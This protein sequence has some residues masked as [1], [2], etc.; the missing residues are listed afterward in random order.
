MILKTAFLHRPKSSTT[1]SI[2]THLKKNIREDYSVCF[3]EDGTL[4]P[5]DADT[6]SFMLSTLIKTG[7]ITRDETLAIA[8]RIADNQDEGKIQIYFRPE[9]HDRKNR[10]DHVALCNICYFLYSQ[11][12]KEEAGNQLSEIVAFFQKKSHLQ[13]SRYYYSPDAAIY[14]ACQLLEFP[15]TEEKLK[16]TLQDALSERVG[17]TTYPLDVAMRITSADKLGMRNEAD[18][19]KLI[20]LQAPDG[21]FPADA[22]Y[23]YG[24][25]EEYFGSKELST[26][27]SIEALLIT[28]QSYEPSYAALNVSKTSYTAPSGVSV[29]R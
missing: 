6:T 22:I 4:L 17:Q 8:K 15:Q 24:S 7:D 11:G 3:F 5:A 23:K 16:T 28:S 29:V 1:S 25:K 21:S 27:F 12:L 9:T 14:F 20:R 26:A 19:Q 2:I 18:F 13:G 10:F